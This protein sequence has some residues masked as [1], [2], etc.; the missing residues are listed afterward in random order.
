MGNTAGR[1]VKQ[2]PKER[3]KK[4][5]IILIAIL[6]IIA[7]GAALGTIW[8]K[9]SVKPPARLINPN[10][11]S[12]LPEDIL[13]AE[14]IYT[15]LVVGGDMDTYHTDTI[16]VV[17]FDTDNDKINILSIPRD[18]MS[19][20]KRSNKKI[21]GA[22][23]IG[24]IEQLNK[25]IQDLIGFTPDYHVVVNLEGF[26]DLIDAMGGVKINVPRNMDYEDPYQDLSIHL[27]KGEQVLNGQQAMGFVRFRADY[28]NGDLER[29]GV[30]QMFIAALAQQLAQP[31]TITKLP[32]FAQIINENMETNLSMGEII[33]FGKQL[34]EVD[35]S[36]S[37]ET[38]TLPGGAQYV[39]GISYFIPDGRRTLTMINE[40]FNPFD[41]D[42][43]R[44]NIVNIN[45]GTTS[46]TNN[47]KRNETTTEQN[48]DN[49]ERNTTSSNNS[50]SQESKPPTVPEQQSPDDDDTM[51]EDIPTTT[52]PNKNTHNEVILDEFG[53]PYQS[54]SPTPTAPEQPTETLPND[55]EDNPL[56]NEVL[57]GE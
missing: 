31:S 48:N 37:L 2:K 6:I 49:G 56:S 50:A 46:T 3:L 54:D 47:D 20:V 28:R 40:S 19:N 29:I 38:F 53:Q 8:W 24:G 30:Q 42:I 34:I 23:A 43:T 7:I 22:H 5:Y 33:W 14:G 51:G 52:E 36:N 45:T 17:S 15:F 9:S 32:T 35:M 41:Q 11:V 57:A 39:N 21:N 44:L 27:K 18:T 10:D 1:H 26:I 12:L 4:R 55:N 25:E 13:K 16:M